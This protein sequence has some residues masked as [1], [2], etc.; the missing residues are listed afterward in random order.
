MN[1][2]IEQLDAEIKEL[3]D[4]L[5]VL[6]SRREVIIAKLRP[7]NSNGVHLVKYSEKSVAVIGDSRT[8]KDELKKLGGRYNPNLKYEGVNQAGW[9]FSLAK[10]SGV[11][12]LLNMSSPKRTSP[13]KKDSSPKRTSPSRKTSVS[14][15]LSLRY[16][17]KSFAVFGDS[18]SIKDKLKGAGGRYN[19]RLT[20]AGVKEAGWIFPN[21]R[22]SEVRDILGAQ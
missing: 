11:R 3:S 8:I 19:P 18:R 21:R 9:I 17:E 5:K 6:K 2:E 10:E 4:R 16:S 20:N 14:P 13:S 22:E 7:S 12:N 15:F 1:V